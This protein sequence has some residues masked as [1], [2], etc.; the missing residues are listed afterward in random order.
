MRNNFFFSLS[1]YLNEK[2]I[3]K[4]FKNFLFNSIKN[5]YLTLRK[6]RVLTLLSPQETISF[7][8]N[9]MYFLNLLQNKKIDKW[10]IFKLIKL[11]EFSKYSYKLR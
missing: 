3:K 2:V 10:F 6:Y 9:N 7:L 8:Y 1:K 4:N 5:Y 11:N